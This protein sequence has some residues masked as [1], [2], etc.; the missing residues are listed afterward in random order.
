M[1]D[2]VFELFMNDVWDIRHKVRVN[3]RRGRSNRVGGF[4]VE[5]EPQLFQVLY[6]EAE[7]A[8]RKSKDERDAHDI[9]SIEAMLQQLQ[10]PIRARA[11]VERMCAVAQ[12]V[13]LDAGAT[14]SKMGAREKDIYVLLHGLVR[15]FVAGSTDSGER[16]G[17]TRK[18]C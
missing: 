8:L 6:P 7:N 14:I 18:Y 5:N 1:P 3:E 16:D 2:D 13:E 12:Y 4:A 15:T 9:E 17:Q 10:F 11:A